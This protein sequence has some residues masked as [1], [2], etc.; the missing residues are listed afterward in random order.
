MDSKTKIRLF[1]ALEVIVWLLVIVMVVGFIRYKHEKRIGEYRTYRIFMQDVDGL[2]EGSSVRMMGVPIGYIKTI[3]IVQ[4]EVY[5]KFVV[6]EENVE[7]PSGVIATV[8]FNGMAGSK[9]LEIYPPDSYSKASGKLI[10]IKRTSR[11]GAALGLFDDMFAKFDSIVVRCNHFSSQLEQI[12]PKLDNVEAEYDAVTEADKS[13]GLLNNLIESLDASRKKYIDMVKPKP[14]K[15][16]NTEDDE[17]LI[18][19]ENTDN[20]Q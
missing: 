9:S 7:L 6:T 2:I 19:E 8:E 20:G 1:S 17:E 10:T 15:I 12:F 3:N 14:K 18:E 16:I 11:L 5:V 13:V 4:D